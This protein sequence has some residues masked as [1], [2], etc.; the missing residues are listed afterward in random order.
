MRTLDGKELQELK[1][2]LAQVR[3]HYPGEKVDLSMIQDVVLARRA[4]YFAECGLKSEYMLRCLNI[5]IAK[6]K[7]GVDVFA[8]IRHLQ[9]Y[10]TSAPSWMF[11]DGV[12]MR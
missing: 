11:R 12:K 7:Q 4:L 6:I 10:I 1:N 3:E 5:E 9:G 2:L 8:R